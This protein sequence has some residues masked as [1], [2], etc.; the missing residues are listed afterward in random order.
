MGTLHED[1]CTFMILSRS[2]L[3]MRNIS[4]KTCR[5]NQNTHFILSNFSRKSYRLW[6]NVENRCRAGQVT[7]D[8]PPFVKKSVWFSSWDTSD[9]EPEYSVYSLQII[10]KILSN[11]GEEASLD[12]NMCNRICTNM[13]ERL[14]DKVPAVR[15]QTVMAL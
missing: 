9:Q 5:K 15:T 14:Q 12:D 3:R 4:D 8:M 11:L 6:D 13:L 10:N 2:V 7:E 1:L